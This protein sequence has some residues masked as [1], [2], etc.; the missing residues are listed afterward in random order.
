MI[1]NADFLNRIL[2]KVLTAADLTSLGLKL[3]PDKIP[4]KQIFKSEEKEL[5][6]IGV[7]HKKDPESDT[8][9]IIKS[10]LNDFTPDFIFVEGFQNIKVAISDLTRILDEKIQKYGEEEYK[11]RMVRMHGEAIYLI[12]YA[13]INKIDLDTIEGSK[14]EETLYLFSFGYSCNE[15]FLKYCLRTLSSF[16]RILTTGYCTEVNFQKHLKPTI[17]L[18]QKCK[19]FNESTLEYSKFVELFKQFIG[20]DFDVA[21]KVSYQSFTSAVID[22]HRPSIRFN[23]QSQK[24]AELRDRVAITKIYNALKT[25]NKVLVVMGATHLVLQEK[26]IQLIFDDF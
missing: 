24:L 9:T 2:E 18:L 15:I 3:F 22:I 1:T 25:H 20:V 14:E 8:L 19:I 23:Q 26:A 13:L 16:H 12:L 7:A 6:Y 4:S 11:N 5:A 21:D 10:V 17:E